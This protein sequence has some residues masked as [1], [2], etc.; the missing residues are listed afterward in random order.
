MQGIASLLSV[1]RNDRAEKW[2]I[3]KK[4]KMKKIAIIFILTLYVF[5]KPRLALAHTLG[6]PPFLKINGKYAQNNP[7]YQGSTTLNM[8]QDEPPE[9]YLVN[10]PVQFMVDRDRL[11]QQ[12]A[13]PA[14]F[15][16]KLT[17]R[18][19]Y[20]QGTNFEKTGIGYTSGE[21]ATYTFHTPTSYL[22]TLEAKSPLDQDYIIIDIVQVNIVSDMAYALP[23]AAVFVGTNSNDSNT[24]VLFVSQT[25]FDPSSSH[26][27]TFWDFNDGKIYPG[28]T[29][30]R[31]FNALNSYTIGIVF[32]RSVDA[33]GFIDDTGFNIENIQGKLK[34]APFGNMNRIP[35]RF[36]TIDQAREANTATGTGRNGN[37]PLPLRFITIFVT[38]IVVIGICALLVLLE[39][40]KKKHVEKY[41][42]Q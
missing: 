5:I 7:Y 3:S 40:I 27:E 6:G 18:W 42:R 9:K 13:I 23:K 20:A 12:T 4:T 34:F 26:T 32:M 39:Y 10:H 15:A 14:D 16:R 31:N 35:V 17:F 25:K 38:S 22:V 29:I 30:S 8:P 24:P 37:K 33:N 41:K 28:A 2:N 11:A 19:S 21:T 36:G 1:A